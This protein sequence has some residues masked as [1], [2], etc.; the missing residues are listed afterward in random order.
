MQQLDDLLDAA[1]PT[2]P[3]APSPQSLVGKKRG[4]FRSGF[5]DTTD[6]FIDAIDLGKNGG[7]LVHRRR[8]GSKDWIRLRKWNRH[9]TKNVWYPTS[10]GFVIELNRV[11]NLIDALCEAANG[12]CSPKPEW[13]LARE[14]AEESVLGT[15]AEMDMHPDAIEQARKRLYQKRRGTH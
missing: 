12:D 8:H 6:Y 5:H 4:T 2:L 1:E 7:V 3:S 9:N 13:L 15:M 11:G 14:D 10:R